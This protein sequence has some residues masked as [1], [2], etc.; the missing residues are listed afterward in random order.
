MNRNSEDDSFIETRTYRR[1]VLLLGAT[2][3]ICAMSVVLDL[4]FP[5]KEMLPTGVLCVLLLTMLA[6]PIGALFERRYTSAP[7]DLEIACGVAGGAAA[8][9]VAL[10]ASVGWPSTGVALAVT[11]VAAGVG[12]AGVLVR[13]HIRRIEDRHQQARDTEL[14]QMRAALDDL[15]A[16]ATPVRLQ[17]DGLGSRVRLATKILLRGEA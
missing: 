8:F 4:K 15:R 1:V 6:A 5:P 16:T 10:Y 2:V 14:S 9:G 13:I 17:A 11:A 3:I 12:S 7:H